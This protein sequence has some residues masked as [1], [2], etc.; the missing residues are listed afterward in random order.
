MNRVPAPIAT[1]SPNYRL[2]IDRLLVLLQSCSIMASKCISKLTWSWL[3]IASPNPLD[4]GFQVHIQTRSI[5]ALKC[6]TKVVWSWLPIASPKLLH[7]GL[8]VHL[9]THLIAASKCISNLP[10][11]RPPRTSRNSLDHLLGVYSRVQ[12]NV[13]FR[14]TSKRGKIVCVFRTMRWHLCTPGSPKYIIPVTESISVIS[15][16]PNGYM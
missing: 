12:S 3:P 5:V 7:C 10:W 13:I 2:H 14:R 6:I 11:S 15:V 16:S 1:L 4:H 9:Q 8:E